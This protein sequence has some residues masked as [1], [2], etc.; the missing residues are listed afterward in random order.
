MYLFENF[1]DLSASFN[2]HSYIFRFH[3]AEAKRNLASA[4]LQW[5]RLTDLCESFGGM[6]VAFKVFYVSPTVLLYEKAVIDKNSWVYDN[7]LD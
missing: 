2:K 7:L 3:K 1:S 4:I 6:T 5:I